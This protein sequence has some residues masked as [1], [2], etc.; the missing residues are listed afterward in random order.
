MF[1]ETIFHQCKQ[2]QKCHRTLI[3]G[4]SWHI[5][6]L[7]SRYRECIIFDQRRKGIS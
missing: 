4:R 5:Q 6:G 2:N 7:I 3:H 1:H